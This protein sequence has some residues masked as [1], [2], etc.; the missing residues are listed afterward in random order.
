GEVHAGGIPLH[1][2]DLDAWRRKIAWV[3]Q[4][5]HL[6]ARTIAENLRIGRAAATDD[7]LWAALTAASL[8]H[9]VAA[10]PDGLDTRLGERG[11]GL[12]VGEAQRLAL[13]RAF[14]RDAPM[15]LLDEPTAHL[16]LDTEARVIDALQTLAKDR[17]VVIVTHRPAALTI[18]DRVVVLEPAVVGALR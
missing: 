4:R 10:M 16:D 8:H 1:E 3:P 2:M 6:F 11:A 5:P 9:R 12:S 14:V 7:E 18:A 17:T 13:A 15:L